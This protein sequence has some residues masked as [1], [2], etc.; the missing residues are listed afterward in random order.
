M[1]NLQRQ[2]HT[3]TKGNMTTDEYLNM[4]KRLSEELSIVGYPVDDMSMMFA[5][6]RGLGHDYLHFNISMNSNLEN[7][8]FE[9]LVTNL[10][11]HEACLSLYNQGNCTNSFPPMSKQVQASQEHKGVTNNQPPTQN[12]GGYQNY[13]GNRGGR[14][15]R[16]RDRGWNNNRYGPRF[17]IYGLWGQ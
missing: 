2:I 7:R 3:A 1:S 10:K 5:F 9:K 16:G 12:K 15:N 4:F 11:T 13:N 17:Q 14:Q 6:L 8:N